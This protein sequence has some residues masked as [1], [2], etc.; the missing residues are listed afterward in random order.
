MAAVA[1]VALAAPG[2]ILPPT[3]VATVAVTVVAT[4]AVTVVTAV[5][6]TVAV[7]AVAAMQTVV[8][9]VAS[10]MACSMAPVAGS[11]P[12]ARVLA[13]AVDRRSAYP[14]KVPFLF[15]P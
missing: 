10:T 6:A 9:A 11:V 2:A 7:T 3:V 14:V 12:A 13:V 1:T 8:T 4:V 15:S 5:V